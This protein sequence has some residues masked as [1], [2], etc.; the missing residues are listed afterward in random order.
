VS[1]ERGGFLREALFNGNGVAKKLIVALVLFS[2]VITTVITAIEL[3]SGYRR[4]LEQI[5]RSIDF[6]SKSYLASLIDSVWVADREQ[7]QTQLDGLLRLPDIEYLG[8]SVDGQTR[9]AAGQAVSKRVV[10]AEVPLVR[11]HR[12]QPL[13]IGTVHIVA[14][15]DRVL[16][17][18]WDQLLVVLLG[19]A[20]KTLLVAG[21]MLLVF[22]YL[23]TRHLTRIAAFVRRIDPA[24]PAGE[25]VQLDR[26]PSGR[27]RPDI[28]D[29]VTSSVNG[30]SRSL[31]GAHED[32]LRSDERL[33]TL[34]RETTAFIYELDRDGRI[35]FANRTYPG[36]TREQVEGTPLRDWFTPALQAKVDETMARAFADGQPQR[37]EYTIPDPQGQAHAYVASL[38]PILRDGTVSSVALTA[39]DISEQKA[40]EQQIRDLNRG[41]EARVRER[42]AELQRAMERAEAASRAKSEFLSRMSHELRTPM[43]A[44]LGFAQ[45][46]EMSN[47]TSQQ[48]KWTGEIRR[49]GDHL[50]QMIE[51]L[52]D[53]ARIEVGKLAIRLEP[54]DLMPIVAESAAIVQPLIAAR[55]L[56]LVVEEPVGAGPRV[57]ADRLRLRQVIV[58]LLSNAAKYNRES[59]TITVRC[60]DNAAGVRLSVTDTGAGIAGEKLA[61]LFQP[62]DRL[63]AELGNVEGTG[64]GLALSKQLTELM[65]ATLGAESEL[66]AGSTFWVDLPRA[67]GHPLPAVAAAGALHGLGDVPLDVLY[68]EDNRSNV[69]VIAAFLAP[70]AHVQLRTATTGD[71]GLALARA[72][73]PDIILLD[74]H[75]PGMDGYQVLQRL[76][77]D[78]GLRDIPVIALSADAMP[79][80]VQRGLAAGF[81]RYIAKPVDLTELSGTLDT[82]LRKNRT[83]PPP[84]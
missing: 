6:V 75:L 31:R 1:D 48:L 11:E 37:L 22:Q 50:L 38:V 71:A 55:G 36:L 74:I 13:T 81:D 73:R 70:R 10:T 17:R 19:N 35:V 54:L 69:E 76:R 72:R 58:N 59:G 7:V 27:W 79:H 8:I 20:V 16:A 30:L 52:L 14:S 82:L 5:D 51:D 66:G 32:L 33:R 57:Q 42:T 24:A 28:L 77:A 49:A 46:I 3:Y 44:I 23:V 34:T 80:D 65:G 56:Q 67:E 26:P 25:Q 9:W 68:I 60:R 15:V 21:F 39:L 43:N 41:L 83:P 18:I 78:A 45:I 64:I 2:S 47:P 12:G 40:A 84:S 53:L 29:A 62:F 63:G 4:D 61:R